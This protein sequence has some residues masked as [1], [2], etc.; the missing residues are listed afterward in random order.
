MIIPPPINPTNPPPAS[1]YEGINP[2]GSYAGLKWATTEEAL[3]GTETAKAMSPATTKAAIQAL[4]PSG[5]GGGSSLVYNLSELLTPPPALSAFTVDN[6]SI[7]AEAN[8]KY[9]A[10]K[11]SGN[12]GTALIKSITIPDDIRPFRVTMGFISNLYPANYSQMCLQVRS[13]IGSRL[14]ALSYIHDNGLKII[15][16]RWTSPSTWNSNF[17]AFLS[18]AANPMFLRATFDGTGV[19]FSF[20]TDGVNFVNHYYDSAWMA[21]QQPTIAAITFHAVGTQQS[22]ATVI[23]WKEEY[24]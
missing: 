5:G 13:G 19:Q 6:E 17:G 18:P 12:N 3:A 24:L 20:S 8:D 7:V 16:S 14:L 22:A 9:I 21:N 4:A 23:S 15:A 2:D 11:G 10:L 1:E